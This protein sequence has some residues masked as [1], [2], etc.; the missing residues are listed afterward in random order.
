M[1]TRVCGSLVDQDRQHQ[2]CL[3][4]SGSL[5]DQDRQNQVWLHV[6]VVV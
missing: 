6:S 3:H 4:V 1:V 5:A 2:V